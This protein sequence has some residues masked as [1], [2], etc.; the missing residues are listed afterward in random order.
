MSM[1]WHETALFNLQVSQHI[2][3]KL[4]AWAG[5]RFLG[6]IR[7]ILCHQRIPPNDNPVDQYRRSVAGAT[8][9]VVTQAIKPRYSVSFQRLIGN[10]CSPM[11]S[12]WCH[13]IPILK[14]SHMLQI[15]TGTVRWWFQ[16]SSETCLQ[17][18]MWNIWKF[19]CSPIRGRYRRPAW[20]R[21]KIIR[22]WIIWIIS[23]RLTTKVSQ[24]FRY[25]LP[26]KCLKP[27]C[28]SFLVIEHSTAQRKLLGSK[29]IICVKGSL[30]LHW[31]NTADFFL[32]KPGKE[33]KVEPI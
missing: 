3:P 7:N 10:D 13:G 11:G 19:T 29:S 32:A 31:K 25:R 17:K 15:T 18:N 30:S 1:K 12:Q 5:L 6:S 24:A 23:Y 28:F 22:P 8:E 33:C 16:P 14:D 21:K 4:P 9:T 20:K 2:P 27:L 26:P